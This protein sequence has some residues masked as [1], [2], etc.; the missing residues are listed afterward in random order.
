MWSKFSL[1]AFG[2]VHQKFHEHV[3]HYLARFSP[4]GSY[5]GDF[6][7]IKAFRFEGEI[8]VPYG[9]L[10]FCTEAAY[11]FYLGGANQPPLRVYACI[12]ARA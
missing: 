8:R 3:A 2:I 4:L 11:L 6:T 7:G 1:M 5:I 12:P 9:M 10:K